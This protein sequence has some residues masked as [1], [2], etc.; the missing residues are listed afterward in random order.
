MGPV[1]G[2]EA[3]RLLEDAGAAAAAVASLPNSLA[4]ALVAACFTFMKVE[5]SCV[6]S[7]AAAAPALSCATDGLAAKLSCA[8]GGEPRA[9]S[10]M[11]AGAAAVS[12]ARD[13][14]ADEVPDRVAASGAS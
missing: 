1:G 9:L 5:G 4:I 2:D 13:D 12:C 8:K 11:G 7:E 14:A 6:S 3:E 10:C